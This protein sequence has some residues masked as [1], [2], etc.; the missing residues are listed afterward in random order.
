M[1]NIM[2]R[3]WEIA[4]K[5]QEQFGGK[6][7]EYLSEA[8]KVAWNEWKTFLSNLKELEKL[9][10]KMKQVKPESKVHDYAMILERT[11]TETYDRSRV[12]MKNIATMLKNAKSHMRAI[13]FKV[14]RGVA[15]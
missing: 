11:K 7:S 9:N 14:N 12:A 2:K 4:R 15:V 10:H 1:K 13:E 5:G 6:V 8:L 3:A